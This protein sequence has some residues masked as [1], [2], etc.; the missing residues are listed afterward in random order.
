[1]AEFRTT[2]DTNTKAVNKVIASFHTSLHQEMES[3]STDHSAIAVDNAKL[4][5]SIFTNIEKLQTDLVIEDK[6]MD[7]LDEKT[8]KAKVLSVK[9]KT[10]QS[11]LMILRARRLWSKAV[12]DK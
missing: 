1:M 4:N 5:A 3:L 8:Q 7:E 9:L 12:F 2:A 11:I 6:I 10:L